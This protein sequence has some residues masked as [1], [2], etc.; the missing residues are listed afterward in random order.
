MKLI[1]IDAK[2]REAIMD[3]N[4]K[5]GNVHLVPCCYPDMEGEYV[6]LD[7][8]QNDPDL[9]VEQVKAIGIVKAEDVVEVEEY[10]PEGGLSPTLRP[11]IQ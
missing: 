6:E 9:F 5:S 7:A 4:A 2:M 1:K 3:A 10:T 11:K 8:V